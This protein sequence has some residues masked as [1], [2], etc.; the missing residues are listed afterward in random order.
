MS[1][2]KDLAIEN[3]KLRQQLIELSQCIRRVQEQAADE[4]I[5]V[6]LKLLLCSIPVTSLPIR[7]Y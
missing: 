1:S 2:Y 5:S 4:E 3:E 6:E 7:H